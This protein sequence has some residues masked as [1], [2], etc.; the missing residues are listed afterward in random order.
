MTEIDA[1]GAHVPAETEGIKES[2]LWSLD[3]TLTDLILPR[4][5]AFRKMERHGYPVLGKDI[6][7]VD[8]E[9]W[10]DPVLEEA[11]WENILFD[12]ERGFEAH[13]LLSAAEFNTHAE[14][15]W[16]EETMQKGLRLFAEHYS[17]LWD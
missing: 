3:A 6:E 11:E 15:L 4:I 17:H 8:F 9:S 7:K 5:K 14:E 10:S 16:A 13:K 2:E 12:I 1:L